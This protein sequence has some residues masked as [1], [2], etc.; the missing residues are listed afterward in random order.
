MTPALLGYHFLMEGHHAL[1]KGKK[2]GQEGQIE[3]LFDQGIGTVE[4]GKRV[5]L[6]HIAVYR[7]L[8]K[9]G[10]VPHKR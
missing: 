8:V 3:A 9:A 1:R 2:E 7:K 6:H 5:G 4:I 10:K